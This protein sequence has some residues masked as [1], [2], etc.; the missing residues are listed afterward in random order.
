MNSN[1][2]VLAVAGVWVLTQ[3]FAGDALR[4]LGVLG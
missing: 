3:L 1:G 4:R 2:I